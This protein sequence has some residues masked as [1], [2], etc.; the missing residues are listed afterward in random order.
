MGVSRVPV[1][2][3]VRVSVRI[4][5]RISGPFSGRT[6]LAAAFGLEDRTVSA[7]PGAGSVSG[8]LCAR[9]RIAHEDFIRPCARGGRAGPER[10]AVRRLRHGAAGNSSGRG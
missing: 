6:G 4:A 5:I 7:V 8:A 10:K 9:S 1:L 3:S 2:I